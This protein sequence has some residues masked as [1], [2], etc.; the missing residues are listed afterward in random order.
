[1]RRIVTAVLVVFML[2]APVA[3]QSQIQPATV[4]VAG[5]PNVLQWPVTTRISRL[6][7]VDAGVRVTFDRCGVWPDVTPPGWAGPLRFT[8]WL[9]LNVGGEWYGAGIIQFWGC[10]QYN[11]GAVY[12]D[13]Q[14]AR[15]WVYDS[16]WSSMVGHQPAPGERI[17]FMVSAGNARGQDDHQVAER[18]DIVELLMPTA[19]V[20][21]P[22][23]PFAAVEGV[24]VPAPA[25]VPTPFPLP[26]PPLPSIELAGVYAQLADI[27]AIVTELARASAEA[28]A[29]I[30]QNITE[31]RTEN[32]TFFEQVRTHWKAIIGKAAV[33]AGPIIGAIFAGRA[34]K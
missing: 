20:S 33:T 31:G 15:N 13:Q 17:G 2:A 28:H 11:G 23:A 12:Q 32:Q 10:D 3:A 8:L 1:M 25:P 4:K 16:R 21:Y 5:S 30:H 34:T 9:F 18:S 27:R 24:F 29:S 14:I 22:P 7:L 19:A 6:E 26:A